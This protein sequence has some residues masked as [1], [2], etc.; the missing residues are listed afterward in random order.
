MGTGL[1]LGTLAALGLF[2]LALLLSLYRWRKLNH[3]KNPPHREEAAR[4]PS[5]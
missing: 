5:R 3:G 2:I 4:Q 1:S